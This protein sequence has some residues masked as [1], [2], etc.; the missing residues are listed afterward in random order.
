MKQ[1]PYKFWCSECKVVHGGE[2]PPKIELPAVGS[3]WMDE[4]RL[5]TTGEW[6]TVT[7]STIP[8]LV[9]GIDP[10]KGVVCELLDYGGW[11]F[12]PACW[13]PEGAPLAAND[14]L[15]PL[16]DRRRMVRVGIVDV[17]WR[18]VRETSQ[19]GVDWERNGENDYIVRTCDQKWVTIEEQDPHKTIWGRTPSY[20]TPKGQDIG[21][22]TS[23]RYRH[24][25]P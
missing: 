1:E 23:V 25:T 4:Y 21:G 22:G 17:G 6:K 20:F 14:R 24:L 13:T 11:F 7:S 3:L 9:A 19:N 15:L 10:V 8:F 12:E 16:Y 2:C 18:L 5:R